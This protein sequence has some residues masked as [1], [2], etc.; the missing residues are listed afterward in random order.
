MFLLKKVTKKLNN[1]CIYL[2]LGPLNSEII[3]Y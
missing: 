3:D 1:Y 2:K